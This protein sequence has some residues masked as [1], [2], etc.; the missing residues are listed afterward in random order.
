LVS[1]LAGFRRSDVAAVLEGD[2]LKLSARD[3]GGWLGGETGFY[4][5]VVRLPEGAASETLEAHF[6]DGQLIVRVYKRRATPARRIAIVHRPTGPLND[7]FWS[8]LREAWKRLAATF[9]GAR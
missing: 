6:A 3:S 9:R 1:Q 8:R 7:G 2:L 5:E 4:D